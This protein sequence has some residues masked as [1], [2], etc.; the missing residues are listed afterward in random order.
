MVEQGTINI[1]AAMKDMQDS[2]NRAH[3]NMLTM[4]VA[5]GVITPLEERCDYSWLWPSEC[6]HCL[7]HEPD[8]EEPKKRVLIDK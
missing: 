3:R 7:G 5:M 8:W 2:I 1:T 6:A 4:A